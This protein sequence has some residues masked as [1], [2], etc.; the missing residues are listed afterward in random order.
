MDAAKY[1]V[2][3]RAFE[4]KCREIEASKRP[5][6]IKGNAD[7]LKNFKESGE[8]FDIPTLK[9]WGVFFKKH[10][11]AIYSFAKDP[12]GPQAEEMIGRF[13]DASIYLKLGLAVAIDELGAASVGMNDEQ[14]ELPF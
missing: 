13:A 1:D 3:V 8:E 2:V 7:V 11:D 4:A 12:N 9:A 14:L 10:I 6:Y 5:A